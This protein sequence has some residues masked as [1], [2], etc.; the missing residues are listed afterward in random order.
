MHINSLSNNIMLG[1]QNRHR[2]NEAVAKMKS[3]NDTLENEK[4][5]KVQAK[6]DSTSENIYQL[7]PTGDVIV[8]SGKFEYATDDELK[9]SRNG[10]LLNIDDKNIKYAT[11]SDGKYETAHLINSYA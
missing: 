11:T 8:V 2:R 3:K 9:N 6:D 4:A 7:T 1:L 5:S 10:V